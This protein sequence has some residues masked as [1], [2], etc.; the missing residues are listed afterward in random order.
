M[1]AER[2]ARV[3][4]MLGCLL[5]TSACGVTARPGPTASDI[6]APRGA[7][8]AFDLVEITPGTVVPHALEPLPAPA[9]AAEG[10][11]SAAAH[12]IM[13]ADVLN[14]VIFERADGGL[15]APASS[16]GTAFPNVRVDDA[17]FITLPYAGRVRVGGATTARA[18][19]LIGG[20]LAGV[21]IEPQIFVNL[22]ASPAHS[23]LVAGEV[24]TPGRVTLLDGSLTAVDAIAR[25]GGPSVP[26]HALH[27]VIHGPS[28]TR[29]MP[30]VDLLGRPDIAVGM[31]DQI[32]LEP[33]PSRFLAM[34][35]LLRPGVQQ[36]TAPR[37][38]L[39]DGIGEAGGLADRAASPSGVFLFRANAL[40]GDGQR[41]QVFH[42]DMSRAESMLL[43]HRF[44][45]RPDD[46]IYVSNA[47]LWEV[48][49]AIA[50][51][52]NVLTLGVGGVAAAG[53]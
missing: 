41:P 21:A 52:L 50:P 13:P 32:I 43:A 47:P 8:A 35:A 27:A 3:A 40:A 10:S 51:F 6:L 36:M 29:R 44:A 53:N 20:A 12:R 26:G 49:K 28:G 38:S 11:R 25:A 9:A 30:Y 33:R 34:G 48:Q 22:V 37:M 4:L 24:R 46:V 31:G 14:V 2:K 15:F 1:S 45:L 5:A 17:G 16:G 39:L 7:E 19:A 18:A 23:V 42:L